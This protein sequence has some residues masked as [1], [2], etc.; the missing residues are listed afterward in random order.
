MK[1]EMYVIGVDYGTDSVRSIIADAADG[2]II[3]SSVHQYARWKDALFCNPSLNQ[4]RQHPLDYIEG[5]E[6]TVTRCLLQAGPA[7]AANIK[8]ISIDTTG[9]TPVA[10]DETGTPLAL[11]L[12]VVQTWLS[13][14]LF[15]VAHDAMHGSLAPGRPR[16]NRAIGTLCLLLYAQLSFAALL[17]K[18]FAH[19]AHAGSADDPDF[20]AS[21]P[22]SLFSWFARFFGGYYSHGQIVR[23]TL[24][25]FVY[26]VLL[27]APWAN[28]VA[29]WAIPSIL[30]LAQLFLFGTWLPHRHAD[31][32]FA[33]RHNA[34]NVALSPLGSLLSCFHFGGYHHQ[35][36]L[37]PGVP[38]W[39]LPR[40]DTAPRA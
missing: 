39:A 40:L 18:H 38:W 1:N 2:T 14:G 7:V 32:S 20:H 23:L 19:H 15:I 35:H 31:D 5:L 30:A 22:R 12:I 11:L 37:Q 10:V 29:F 3:A 28:V 4:F 26:I 24:V 9:S 8:A 16:T 13:T 21:R 27:R 34:R 25:A 33:D 6:Q 17:P 36:H